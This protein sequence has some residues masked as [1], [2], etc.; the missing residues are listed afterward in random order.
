MWDRLGRPLEYHSPRHARTAHAIFGRQGSRLPPPCPW[1]RGPTSRIELSST[2]FGCERR[3]LACWLQPATKEPPHST[4][5]R[6][7]KT[8]G[9]EDTR[10]HRVT[11]V[12]ENSGSISREWVRLLPYTGTVTYLTA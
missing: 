8:A 12:A 2:Q 5:L 9:L 4:Q 3:L 6:F 7:E 11:R 1:R 10:I